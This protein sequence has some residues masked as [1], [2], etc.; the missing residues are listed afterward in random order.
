MTD[1]ELQLRRRIKGCTWLLI[2]GLVVSGVTAI[3]LQTELD[4]LARL[5]GSQ[6]CLP[7]RPVPDL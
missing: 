3:P 2:A 1:R 5:F 4:V 7:T 6:E